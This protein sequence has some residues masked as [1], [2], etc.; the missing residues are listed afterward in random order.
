ME[1][2]S[3]KE[4]GGCTDRLGYLMPRDMSR[5]KKCCSVV[6]TFIFEEQNL[7]VVTHLSVAASCHWINTA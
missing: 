5:Y 6:E 4:S 2:F 7:F 3:R 1:L